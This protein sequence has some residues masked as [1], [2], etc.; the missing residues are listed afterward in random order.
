MSVTGGMA[1]IIEARL[2]ASFAVR[3]IEVEDQS[4]AHAGH[5][6]APAGGESHFHVRM[7]TPE[8]A[9]LSRIER[10]RAV[11]AALGREV[12]GRVHAL[13]LDLGG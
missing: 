3:E 5:A 8:L 2:R 10:H 1:G 4:A 12:T 11:H 13:S 6:G 7:R 9:S